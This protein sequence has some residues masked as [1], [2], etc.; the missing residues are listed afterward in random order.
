MTSRFWLALILSAAGAACGNGSGSSKRHEGGA[1]VPTGEVNSGSS[2]N[3]VAGAVDAH[4]AGV[5]PQSTN[6]SDCTV[7][8]N[9][10]AAPGSAVPYGTTMYNSAGDDDGCKYHVEWSSPA[11][12]ENQDARFNVSASYKATGS[13]NP[14]ACAGCPVQGL[15]TQ[16]LLAE[17]YLNETHPAPNSDQI[18]TP[19]AEGTYTIGP[20][21]FDAPGTWTVR[22]HLFET[23][24]DVAAESPH[25]QAAF[26]VEVP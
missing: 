24:S 4:C 19:G 1:D 23:C 14:P 17:V 20:V 6:Q 10:D 9:P 12:A 26:Y 25:G 11:I 15:D 21:L 18:T 3:A 8:V 13:P 2:P 22:F 5:P 7:A 16:N